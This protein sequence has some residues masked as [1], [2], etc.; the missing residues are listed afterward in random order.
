[1]EPLFLLS[2]DVRD[3][4]IGRDSESERDRTDNSRSVDDRR[5]H[6]GVE[7]CTESPTLGG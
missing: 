5:I 6:S 1:M 4:A 3:R 7:V 2:M